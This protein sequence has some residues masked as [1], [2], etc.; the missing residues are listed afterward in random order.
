MNVFEFA[1]KMELDGKVYYESLAENSQHPGV[2]KIFLEMAADEQKHYDVFKRLNDNEG[3]LSMGDS[4]ALA[5]AKSLFCDMVRGN[6]GEQRPQDDLAAYRKALE[7]EAESA[8]LYR[9]AAHKEADEEVRALLL[10]IAAEEDNH[11]NIIENIYLFI[12]E[13]NTAMV[14]AESSHLDDFR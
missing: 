12:N 4:T 10:R 14:W 2:K 6:S 1:M 9:E 7:V 3:P 8:K 13:P 11:Y 5:E